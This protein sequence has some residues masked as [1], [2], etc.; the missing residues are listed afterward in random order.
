MFFIKDGS[1]RLVGMIDGSKVETF[2]SPLNRASPSSELIQP[3]LDCPQITR[4][5]AQRNTGELYIWS[6]R[7]SQL[8]VLGINATQSQYF[9]YCDAIVD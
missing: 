2:Q 1:K 9:R 4:I 3:C 6:S 5:M 7:K 8:I